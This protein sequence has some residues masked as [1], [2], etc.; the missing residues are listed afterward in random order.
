MTFNIKKLSDK[1]FMTLTHIICLI[2]VLFLPVF[3]PIEGLHSPNLVQWI[4]M[5]GFGIVFT[6]LI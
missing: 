1:D 3:F 4:I 6:L 2:V 5:I